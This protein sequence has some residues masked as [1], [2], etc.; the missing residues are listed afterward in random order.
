MN[1]TIAATIVQQLGKEALY[2]MGTKQILPIKDGNGIS[3]RIPR[4]NKINIITITLNAK[5]LYDI[6]FKRLHN[7]EVKVIAKEEDCY[8]DMLH[9]IISEHTG[10]ALRLPRIIRT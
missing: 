7:F 4:V 8:C 9:N 1:N 5:D 2:M 10:L 3:I 6:E